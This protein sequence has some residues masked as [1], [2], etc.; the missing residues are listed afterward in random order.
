MFLLGKAV[1]YTSWAAMVFLGFHLAMVKKYENPERDAPFVEGHF[2]DAAL[3]IDY[4]VKDLFTLFTKPGM[5][6]ML[7]DQM[8]VPGMMVPKTLVVNLN[9]TLVWQHYEMGVGMEAYKRPGLSTFLQRMARYYEVVVFGMSESGTINEICE[10]L[11]PKNQVIVGRFGREQTVLKE[12]RYIKDLSY[13]NRPIKNV[14]YLDFSDE[15]I[16]YHKENCILLP[17][18]EGDTSDRELVD[19]IPFLERK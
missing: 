11:D 17:K 3:L 5:T 7:P 16:D 4:A 8:N 18:F 13:L 6:K 15:A 10:A 14:I 9:G 1:K 12:G 2:L 19:L